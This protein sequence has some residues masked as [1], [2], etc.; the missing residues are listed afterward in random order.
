M[1]DLPFESIFMGDMPFLKFKNWSIF[2]DDLLLFINWSI[3][4]GDLPFSEH[5]LFSQ[6]ACTF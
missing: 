4:T 3:F 6:T 1:G 5:G 2:L